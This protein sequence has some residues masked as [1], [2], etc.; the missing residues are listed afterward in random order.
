MDT[1]LLQIEKITG[2]GSKNVSSGIFVARIPIEDG[3]LGNL[4][5][6][7]L[8]NDPGGQDAQVTARDIFEIATK[9]L[10]GA[11]GGALECLLAAKDGAIDYLKAQG[12]VASFV[13]LTF[14]KS[15]AYI[16][17]QGNN[18][19]IFVARGGKSGEITFDHG[20]GPVEAGQLYLVAT[21]EFVKSFDVGE[22][23]GEEINLQELV[24][25]LATEISAMDDSKRLAAA[26]V[27]VKGDK[28]L[29]EGVGAKKVEEESVDSKSGYEPKSAGANVNRDQR[30]DVEKADS[31]HTQ[32]QQ[33]GQKVNGAGI[34]L[35]AIKLFAKANNALALEIRKIKSN[36]RL[37]ILRLRRNLV[38]VVAV[39]LI[40]LAISAGLA[41]KGKRD[42]QT[43]AAFNDHLLAASTKF[44]EGE[45][46]LGL[47]RER[48]RELLIGAGDEVGRALSIRPKDA[49]ALELKGK[50]DAKLKDSENLSGLSFSTLTTT[51]EP[52]VSLTILGKNIVGGG[53]VEGIFVVDFA[54]KSA[55]KLD[56]AGGA[57]SAFAF[58]DSVFTLTD[59][60]VYKVNLANKKNEKVAESKDAFDIAVFVGNI[61]LL[62]SSA[63]YKYVPVEGD[64]VAGA[65]Y[66]QGESFDTGSR[67]AIDGSVWVTK[68]DK[69]L[70]YLKGADQNFTIFGL[71]SEGG[72]FGEI[73]TT[74]DTDNLYVIDLANKALLA[75]GK[76]DGIFKKAYQANEFGQA[77]GLVVDEQ[78]GKIY[79]S[80]DNKILQ[81]DL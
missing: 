27:L 3:A 18:V 72:Q 56:G 34:V 35:G 28:S 16:A 53:S 74:A 41:V 20:S 81:A 78:T 52:L 71:S 19:K 10:E 11:R 43:A 7:I 29:E 36:E 31:Y 50:I 46:I 33:Q 79:I 59:D 23:L 67:M 12:A 80:V 61:Y 38:L 26:L 44:S 2:T 37:A 1:P 8:V 9:K 14:Y 60:G 51:S 76:D 48:A 62:S 17:R 65:D 45:A 13:H 63:I 68:G 58:N 5:S 4:V 57:K 75:I 77:T 24:D 42:R 66:V 70:K 69:I 25:G 40:I 47:N 21:D 6:C 32:E 64:Y 73:F 55:D 49:K 22:F 54:S 39:I 15:A 30:S